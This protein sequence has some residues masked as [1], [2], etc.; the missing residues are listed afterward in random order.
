MKLKSSHLSPMKPTLDMCGSPS[1][2]EG[3]FIQ[4]GQFVGKRRIFPARRIGKKY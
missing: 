3:F 1:T 4:V 2:E